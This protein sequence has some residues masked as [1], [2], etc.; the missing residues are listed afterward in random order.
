MKK[1]NAIKILI[2]G[3]VLIC[4]VLG[5]YYYLSNKRSEND[6]SNVKL[7]A[8]QEALL[9]N[10]DNNYPPTPREVVKCFCEIAQCLYGEDYTEEEFVALAKQVQK[11]YD[12]EL[13]ANNTEEQYIGSLKWDI[14]NFKEQEIVISSYTLASSTDVD[15]FT[16]DGYSWAQMRCTFNLRKGTYRQAAEE[17]FLLRKD[18]DGHWK[19]YGWTLEK[20]ESVQSDSKQ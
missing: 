11:L 2:I 18:A 13:I 12:E 6:S 16:Q 9:R 10:L 3:I 14:E 8:V 1:Q 7:T 20:D 4:L 15:Q 19:I 5:Y 17:I